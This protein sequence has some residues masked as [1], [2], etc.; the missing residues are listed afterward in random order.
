MHRCNNTIAYLYI[1]Y[2]YIFIYIF[3]Y[4]WLCSV[5]WVHAG[6]LIH[7]KMTA[8]AVGL[9]LIMVSNGCNVKLL[10]DSETGSKQTYSTVLLTEAQT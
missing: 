1:I 4:T 2:I 9:Q 10:L 7:C 5:I 6:A 8:R 3:I